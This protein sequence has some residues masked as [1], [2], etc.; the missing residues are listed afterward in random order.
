MDIMRMVIEF[1]INILNTR[2]TFGEYSF[3][4]M[5]ASLAISA[6][7]VVIYFIK[8]IFDS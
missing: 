5:S 2:L 1:T 4:I 3:T 8:E 7:A 6:L